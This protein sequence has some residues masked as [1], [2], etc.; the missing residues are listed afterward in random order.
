MQGRV[1][2]C[3]LDGRRH[4]DWERREPTARPVHRLGPPGA[5]LPQRPRWLRDRD[6]PWAIAADRTS[7]YWTE[8]GG[9]MSV[10]LGGGAPNRARAIELVATPSRWTPTIVYWADSTGVIERAARRRAADEALLGADRRP[11]ARGRQRARLLD[12]L[13]RRHG[14]ASAAHGRRRDDGRDRRA[15][16]D[17]DRRRWRARRLGRRPARRHRDGAAVGRPADEASRRPR[18]R[19]SKSPS[20]R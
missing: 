12:R 5:S 4:A 19:R 13:R 8:D 6:S 14:D 11:G 1:G 20:T 7:V 9:V 15:S 17:G 3:Q 16:S 18:A 2:V 10:P